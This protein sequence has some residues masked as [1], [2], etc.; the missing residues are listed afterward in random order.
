MAN[1]RTGRKSGFILRAGVMRRETLWLASGPLS[2]TIATADTALLATTLSTVGLALIPFT[3]TRT[4]VTLW[5]RSDALGSAEFQQLFYGQ[6]VVSEQ[7]AAIGVTAVPTPAGDASSD[8]WFV[9]MFQSSDI[10]SRGTDGGASNGVQMI[11]DS[12]AQR[13]VEDG[14]QLISVVETGPNG[15]G[16]FTTPFFR[17]LIKLS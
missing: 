14:E 5:Q 3:V 6:C 15:A 1:I 16:V 13:K 17:Q 8:L 2:L 7:A 11:Q 10:N 9:H 4:I 12:R